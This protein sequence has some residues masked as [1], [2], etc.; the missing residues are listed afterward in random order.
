MGDISFTKSLLLISLFAIAIIGY[1]VGYTSDNNS[2]ISIDPNAELST[3][4]T[5]ISSNVQTFY[6]DTNTSSTVFSEGTISGAEQTTITGGEF[7]VN[8]RSMMGAIGYVFGAV[9]K[10]IFGGNPAFGIIL[11]A[12]SSMLVFIGVRYIWKTWKGG[13][14]D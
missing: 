10:N 4:N 9:N 7:K 6:L 1:S 13:N 8:F 14:P 5:N 2:V 3:M 11:T 12:F